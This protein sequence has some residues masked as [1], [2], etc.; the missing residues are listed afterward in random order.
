MQTDSKSE[1][2]NQNEKLELQK[3]INWELVTETIC[4]LFQLLM[5]SFEKHYAMQW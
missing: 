3:I 1:T 5:Y 2:T 4:V